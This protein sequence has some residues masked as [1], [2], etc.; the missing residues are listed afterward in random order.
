MSREAMTSDFDASA[1]LD[2]P[3]M[4]AAYLNEVLAENDP[5]A[6][7]EALGQVAR[8][9]GMSQL[10]QQAGLSRSAL[11]RALSAR[12]ATQLETVMRVL[13]AMG[14]GLKVAPSRTTEAA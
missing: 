8:A 6:L 7:A 9:R 13:A 2:S 10:A 3:Q 4:I 5:A 14:Y 12:G 11:Y 1:Y